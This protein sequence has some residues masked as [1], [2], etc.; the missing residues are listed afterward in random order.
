[1]HLIPPAFAFSLNSNLDRRQL[2]LWWGTSTLRLDPQNVRSGWMLAHRKEGQSS[3]A[4]GREGW[5]GLGS[6]GPVDWVRTG[7]DRTGSSDADR[8]KSNAQQCIKWRWPSGARCWGEARR[9][10]STVSSEQAAE[11]HVCPR[12]WGDT[13]KK[14]GEIIWG[15]EQGERVVRTEREQSMVGNTATGGWAD[16]KSIP[17]YTVKSHGRRESKSKEGIM[18]H[19]KIYSARALSHNTPI[20]V[21]ASV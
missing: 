21:H 6:D 11:R 12:G 7:Q 20:S 19:F 4:V 1:M 5:T 13:L 10:V 17:L 15:P 2:L 3:S 8:L 16:K 18:L 9:L 14:T